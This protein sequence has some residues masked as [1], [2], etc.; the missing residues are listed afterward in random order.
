MF[1]QAFLPEPAVERFD[2]GV[3]VGLARFDEEQLNP[4]GVGPVQHGPTAEFF[5]VVGPDRLGQAPG[6]GE[7]IQN[8]RQLVAAHG[9]LGYDGHRFVGRVIDDRQVLDDPPLGRPVKDEVHGPYL[10]GRHR[11]LQGMT[12]GQRDLLALALSDLQ[13]RLGIQAL[14]ALVVDDLTGLAQLQVDHARAVTA[15]ALR[16]GDDLVLQGLVAVRGGLVTVGAG[17]HADDAQAAALAQSTAHHV[18]HQLAPCGCAHHFFLKASFVTSFSSR[19]SARSRLRRAFSSSSSLRRL[20][21]ETLIPPNLLR[22]R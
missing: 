10:V 18:A 9:S 14:D 11:T 6:T 1:V 19:D 12:V 20:A 13:P 15:M 16:Q 7:L 8:P 22:Q 21:S 3:L 4:S 5:A 2:V 17:A